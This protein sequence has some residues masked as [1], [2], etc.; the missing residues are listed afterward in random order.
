MIEGEYLLQATRDVLRSGLT[1]V[2]KS[3]TTLD[4]S[5]QITPD[6]RVPAIAGEE[7]IGIYGTQF[8]NLYPAQSA[9]SKESYTLSIGITRRLLAHPLD[10]T[11]DTI[12]TEDTS[13][14]STSKP[15]ML[16]RAREIINLIDGSYIII[17]DANSNLGKGECP[18]FTP[19]GLVSADAQ[20]KYVDEDHFFTSPDSSE[21]P[22]GLYLEMIFGGAELV[23][24]KP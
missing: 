22:K 19:L 4:K 13:V 14:L 16:Q 11:G 21:A 18:F 8:R 12:Y 5:V 23:R 7:F 20:P 24:V 6:E 15:S 1:N 17:N 3:S 10:R 2:T 9:S